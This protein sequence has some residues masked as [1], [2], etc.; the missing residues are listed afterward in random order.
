MRLWLPSINTSTQHTIQYYRIQQ[1]T[2]DK[3]HK[4]KEQHAKYYNK[5][6]VAITNT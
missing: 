6:E 3:H 1:N 4:H 2:G 5:Y